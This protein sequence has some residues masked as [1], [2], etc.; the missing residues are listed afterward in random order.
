MKRADPVLPNDEQALW[1][2]GVFNIDL[3][4]GL[5]YIVFF[6]NCKHFCFRALDEHKQL[7][8]SQ[9]SISV[10]SNGNKEL[11]NTGRLCKNVQGGLNNRNVDVKRI[12]HKSDPSN[13]RCIVKVFD[14]YLQHIPR[15]GRFYRKPL[16][17][18]GSDKSIRFSVQSIEINTLSN[19]MKDLFQAAGIPLE[20]RNI[21]NHSVKVTC[22]TTLFNAGFSDSSVKSRSGHRSGAVETYKRPLKRYMIVS[23]THYSLQNRLS[24]HVILIIQQPQ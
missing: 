10:D 8:A 15:E 4:T 5:C 22:C 23:V 14:K 20:N 3:S 11:H 19:R 17:N 24:Q 9:L 16:V 13:P 7:D 6:D 2:S 18:K 12:T 1:D 21:T